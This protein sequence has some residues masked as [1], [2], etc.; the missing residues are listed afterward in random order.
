MPLH[1]RA[2]SCRGNFLAHLDNDLNNVISGMCAQFECLVSIFKSELM[3]DQLAQ[4]N[5]D[6][7][8]ALDT[9]I[10]PARP[11]HQHISSTMVREMIRYQQ[12]LDNYLPAGTAAVL[13]EIREG[14]ENNNG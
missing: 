9:V 1:K 14:K 6:L 13:R 12:K 10:L 11:E 2:L 4:I 7:E 8:P 5:R 3:S